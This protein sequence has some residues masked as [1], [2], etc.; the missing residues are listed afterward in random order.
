MMSTCLLARPVMATA[1]LQRGNRSISSTRRC[2]NGG[3]QVAATT[4]TSASTSASSSRDVEAKGLK[5]KVGRALVGVAL[6]LSVSLSTPLSASA[7]QPPPVRLMDGGCSLENLDLFKDTRAKFSLEVGTGALPEAVL[8]LGGCSYAG[9]DLTGKVL[10][11]VIASNADFQGGKLVQMEMSRAKVGSWGR[12]VVQ[13]ELT[14][15]WRPRKLGLS[16]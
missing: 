15:G 7:E 5:V 14:P 12:G 6:S 8:D 10:S 16:A 2:S 4:S 9:Q 1:S 11:G 3:V 13:G